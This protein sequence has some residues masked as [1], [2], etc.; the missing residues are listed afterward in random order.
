MLDGRGAY[1]LYE[2]AGNTVPTDLDACG[3]HTGPVPAV[4]YDGVTYPAA[5]SVYHYH[6]SSNPP[7]R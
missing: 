2:S 6:W 3:G 1:G 5:A 7:Y 4:T